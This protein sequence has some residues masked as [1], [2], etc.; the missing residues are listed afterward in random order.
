MS[1]N[2]G[3]VVS[4]SQTGPTTLVEWVDCVCVVM[5]LLYNTVCAFLKD[6]DLFFNLLGKEACRL[7]TFFASLIVLYA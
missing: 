5:L 2:F 4:N 6:L 7:P 3:S 1:A